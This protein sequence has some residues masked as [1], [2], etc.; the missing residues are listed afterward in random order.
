MQFFTKETITLFSIST[1]AAFKSL[2]LGSLGSII[3]PIPSSVSCLMSAVCRWVFCRYAVLWYPAALVVWEEVAWRGGRKNCSW[4]PI[5]RKAISPQ[6]KEE[7]VERECIQQEKGKC[8]SQYP[9]HQECL[10]SLPISL[11][12]PKNKLL[13]LNPSSSPPTLRSLPLASFSTSHASNETY[14]GTYFWGTEHG[15]LA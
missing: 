9:T 15:Q 11:S 12:T 1:L 14:S 3:V 6:R 10:R 13:D 8:T 4:T 7:W 5:Y 2:R